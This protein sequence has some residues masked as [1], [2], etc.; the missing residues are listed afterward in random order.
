ML[1]NKRLY[2]SVLAGSLV[3]LL[4]V[5]SFDHLEKGRLVTAHQTANHSTR[6]TRSIINNLSLAEIFSRTEFNSQKL[7]I[8]EEIKLGYANRIYSFLD[9]LFISLVANSSLRLD[10]PH[11]DK[12]IR[13]PLRHVAF[14]RPPESFKPSGRPT[15]VKKYEAYAANSWAARKNLSVLVTQ[16]PVD[17]ELMLFRRYDPLFFEYACNKQ[18]FQ[19]LL[20]LGLTDQRLV[21]AA[22]D[23]EREKDATSDERVEAFYRI[24]F[25]FARRALNHLWVPNGRVQAL[26][27]EHLRRDFACCFVIGVQFRFGYMESTE[28][29]TNRFVQCVIDAEAEIINTR[30]NGD[31]PVKWFLTAEFEER[32]DHVRKK[33]AQKVQKRKLQ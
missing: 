31:R 23:A 12:Y 10:W 4:V 1:S 8:S 25:E 2:T 27:D 15:S 21:S 20:G 32:F 14:N 26:V 16:V 11:I 6:P 33:Y 18:H 19:L 28:A 3:A 29:E 13:T 30:R 17:F 5:F 7:I 22:L 9:S 24:G